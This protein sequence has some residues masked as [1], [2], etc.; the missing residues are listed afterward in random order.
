[1]PNGLRIIHHHQYSDD[2]N[3]TLAKNA[4]FR[5]NYNIYYFDENGIMITGWLKDTN[6]D[7]YLLE[8]Q[9][10]VTEGSLICGWRLVNSTWYYFLPNG[11]L[12]VDGITPDGYKIDKNGEWHEN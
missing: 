5:L 4:F 3:T 10:I 2:K 1:M 12:L 9:K 6:G 8:W 7:T 11:K